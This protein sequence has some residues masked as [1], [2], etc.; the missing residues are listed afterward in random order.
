MSAAAGKSGLGRGVVWMCVVLLQLL[1]GTGVAQAASAACDAINLVGATTS[2]T[3]RFAA[4]N[5][6][7]GESLT[8]SFFDSVSGIGGNPT[9]ADAVIFRSQSAATAG[10]DY[11]SYS[12]SAGPHS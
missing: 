9:A 11:R 2:Y 3:N 8:I 5:F 10:Y 1:A 7:P 4:A 6:L 12:G